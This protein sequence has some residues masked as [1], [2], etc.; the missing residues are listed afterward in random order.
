MSDSLKA[1]API[2]ET[3]EFRGRKYIVRELDSA[4]E[5]EGLDTPDGGYKLLTLCVYDESGNLAFK[6]ED[7]EALKKSSRLG[8][9]KLFRA[10]QKVNGFDLGA[11]E[12][13]SEAGPV[14]G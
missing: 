4:A 10:A 5:A 12:K 3:V 1:L 13:N 6:S 7:I 11:A 14:A 8:I 2:E 9:T